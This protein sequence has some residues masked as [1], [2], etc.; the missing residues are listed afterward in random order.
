[1]KSTILLGFLFYVYPLWLLGQ[2][3]TI[4]HLGIKEGMSNNYVVSI[5]Q[6]KRGFLWFATEEGLNKFDGIRFT[7]YFK[8]ENPQ[9]KSITG[10]ELNT[11]LD[12]PVDSVLWIGTQRAGL[13]A[14]NYYTDTF[15]YY[16]HEPGNSNSLATND[17]TQ[18]IPSGKDGLW[19]CTYWKGVD[20]FDKEEQTFTHFNTA[21]VD[22]LASDHVWCAADDGNG[23]LYIGHVQHG[24]SVLSI[25]RK[26]AQNFRHHP[27]DPYSLPGDEVQCVYRDNSGNIWVGTNHGLAVFDT[28]KER[29]IVVD[30]SSKL[31]SRRIHDIRQM[32]DNNLW[33]AMEFG[34][35]ALIDL[36]RHLF[37][38]FDQ[39]EPVM[40]H[41][42]DT[43]CGLSNSS[44]RCLFQDSFQ[45]IW[46]G[47]W[48]GGIDFINC[49][50]TLFDAYRYSSIPSVNSLT[51][52]IATSLCLDKE[53]K[54]WIGTDGGGINVFHHG[55][56]LAVYQKEIGG[57]GGQS[58]QA[59]LCD[60]RGGLWF[61]FFY[62]GISY[63]D[64]IRKSF[65][66]IMPDDKSNA[67]VRS[68]YEDKE[69]KVW[70]GT[71]D[72]IYVFHR[73]TQMLQEHYDK[74]NNMVR[75][76]HKDSSGQVWVGFYGGGL[77]LY[78]ARLNRIALFN[79]DTSFPSNT[80]NHIHE[81][82]QKRIWVAT[83]EGLVCFPDQKSL[84][85]KVYRRS[86]GLA[87]THINAIG[88]DRQGNIWVSTNKGISCIQHTVLNYDHLDGVPMGSFSRGSMAYSRE[89]IFYFG[90]IDGV[91]YFHPERV[92]QKRQAPPAII[93]HIE[94]TAPLYQGNMADQLI[95]L[96]NQSSVDLAYTQNRF[97]INFNVQNYAL[98]HQVEYAYQMKGFE[99]TWYQVVAPNSVTFQNLPS[100]KYQFQVKTRIRN[101]EWSDEVTRLNIY[102]ASPVW[103]SR[104]A[105]M[106]YVCLLIGIL[107]AVFYVYK[108]RIDAETLYKLEKQNHEYEQ[109]LNQERLRF[110]TNITHELRTPLTL[111][112]GPLEDIQKNGMLV[113][114][115]AQKISLI[116]QSALRLLNLINQILEFRKA[117]TQNKKLCVGRKDIVPVL[118]EIGW[119]YKELNQKSELD[120]QLDMQTESLDMFFDEEILHII[121]DN[122][123]SN[124]IKYTEK[125][126]VVLGVR[127]EERNGLRYTDIWVSDTGYGIQPEALPYIFDRYY[128]ERGEHQASGTGI[129]LSLVK[130]LVTL[131]EGEIRVD[132]KV[133]EG[134]TFCVSLLTD[135]SYPDSLHN[136]SDVIHEDTVKEEAAS[137]SNTRPLLLVV[138]DNVDIRNYIAESFCDM[139]E[140]RTA[141]NGKE[142][143]DCAV[144]DIPD[145]VV[146]D[147]MMPVMDGNEMCRELKKDVRTSHIPIILLT[148]KDSLQDKEEGYAV[149]AD[150]Y[151]TKPFSATLLHSRIDNLLHSRRQLAE[152]F[153][154][155]PV[156]ET[157]VTR[158][159][160]AKFLSSLNKLDNEF[161][162][163]INTL[164]EERLSSDKIDVSYL[165]D[166]MCMSN[167]SLYRK[168]KALTGLSTNEYVR[169][170]K[171][172]YAEEFL[173]EGK[174]TIS[175]IAFKVGINSVFYFRQ[176]F[177]EEFG[178]NPSEYVKCLKNEA[179]LPKTE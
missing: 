50:R 161:L 26:T 102:I 11:L 32:N 84:E 44:V 31:L 156:K 56:R 107:F 20:Y 39:L 113:H 92:L 45:N 1:M 170:M 34:G 93:T 118:Y 179:S 128:Q 64:P 88:E 154:S 49:E 132:S 125:G 162:Q 27:D 51:N 112:L 42:G 72:G 89:G 61:G 73:D 168:M 74:E 79:V 94:T 63:Y 110:Y 70:V 149:G 8:E 148:A 30:T 83:G 75:C 25:D 29:F 52:R 77:G 7:S 139:F 62:G 10:N 119:K 127:M 126:T 133:G 13:N 174:Y 5:A 101:Q 157:E 109:E 152:Y 22:G 17:I 71:S 130:S 105:K 15:T 99:N 177:K 28:Q 141:A 12:D 104:W 137:D 48:G 147:I 144:R 116:H 47:S 158:E 131:H 41:E 150:S 117:E 60:S 114:K 19:I 178:F 53:G 40:I 80:I 129:G 18:I 46:V 108:K 37:Q 87:N 115:D 167:S 96:N 59:S 100:G 38:S 82:S 55:E 164:I 65:R 163:K 91:C 124:A 35:I 24:F 134:S 103:L 136:D 54:L 175:E 146:S 153:S 176:C 69:G 2:P 90:S 120:I 4:Q 33:V 123:I 67:D 155:K 171:M 76:I 122:L 166:R 143:M 97:S 68:F 98:A 95:H 81:D 21:T 66:Q 151:L 172:K 23:K 16:N 36:S 43:G 3:Y 9:K 86:Q 159:K 78:D 145:I 111:I 58:V 135:N 160:S 169:K 85:Y 106:C 140:I 57:L 165:A 138:E 121:L 6:D 14:Y 173:L 142:G